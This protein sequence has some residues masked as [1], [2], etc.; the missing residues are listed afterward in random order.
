M[1]HFDSPQNFVHRTSYERQ[2][3]T[4]AI[5]LQVL[6]LKSSLNQSEEN[7]AELEKVQESSKAR[8]LSLEDDYS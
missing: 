3:K 5:I 4:D 7:I 1:K 2:R 8:I 6:Q